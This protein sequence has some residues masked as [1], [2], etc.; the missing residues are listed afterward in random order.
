MDWWLTLSLCLGTTAAAFVGSIVFLLVWGANTWR[1][2]PRYI[3]LM[4][5]GT[6][7]LAVLWPVGLSAVVLHYGAK[8]L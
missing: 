5:I 2:G 8:A 1:T 7:V 4:L 3:R 6:W